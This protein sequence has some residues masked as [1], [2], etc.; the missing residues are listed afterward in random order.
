MS[1]NVS[2]AQDST[3]YIKVST[4]YTTEAS[5]NRNENWRSVDTGFQRL[6]IFQPVFKKHILFQDLGNVGSPSRPL[7]FDVNRSIGF[8]YLSNP[9]EVYFLKTENAQYLQTKTPYTDL[10]YA[11]GSNELLFLQ[12]RHSQNILPR[13]NVGFDYQRIT[14]QGFFPRQYTNMYN[15]QI[16]TFYHSKN[17]RYT[18]LANATWNRGI[19][20]ES[21]GIQSDS[22]FELLSGSSKVVSPRLTAAQSRYKNRAV[23][24]TQYWNFGKPHY[25][26]SN[27]DT[28]Y[29]FRNHSH[30]SYTF[31]A[32]DMVYAFENSGNTDSIILPRQY[33]DIGSTTYDSAY[34]GKLSNTLSFN[35]LN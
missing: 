1:R 25:E 21:G 6:D 11:Q 16:T 24:V 19:T 31:H 4:L 35:F 20:E 10:F 8:Q 9:Y 33:Y 2:L 34:Y 18:L 13:F 23:R 29:D 27:Q 12:A 26:Y 22:L 17:K 28:S 14:S 30:I 15:Y 32:E 3:R 5:V 7:L